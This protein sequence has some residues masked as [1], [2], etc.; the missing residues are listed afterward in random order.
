MTISIIV[1]AYNEE[2]TISPVLDAILSRVKNLGEIIVVDD[3]STDRTGE[4]C[5]GY[6]ASTPIVHYYLLS[7]NKGKTEAL[8]EG[9][10]RSTGQIVIVQ[11]A[12][13][14]YDPRDINRV[15]APIQ[16]DEADVV[17]GSRFQT[18]NPIRAFYL[19]SYLANRLITFCSNI[20]TRAR[21]SDVET[22]YKAFRGEIIRHMVITS[23][24]FGFEVEVAAKIA[25]LNLRVTE[26]PIS[27]NGRS[28]AEGKKIGIQ[29]GIMALVY[30]LKYNL[31][32]SKKASFTKF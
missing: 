30:I 8:K 7:C 13:L 21:I 22:C 4:I 27:Y 26:V 19:G 16:D 28:Y 17:F 29:D 9:F 2:L 25:K 12:D 14:E 24:R 5:L 23:R 3:G 6:Q 18:R 11:D 1:P 15:V 10:K 20:F 32:C 31:F